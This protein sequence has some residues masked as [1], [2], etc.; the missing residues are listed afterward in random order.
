MKSNYRTVRRGG[1]I[2]VATLSAVALAACSAGQITQTSNQV[3]AVD[4]ARGGDES[5][6]VSVQDVTVI[7]DE[8]TGDAA[9]KF[10][11]QNQDPSG[12]SY[13]L[14]SVSVDGQ[15][16]EFEDEP[17]ALEQNCSFVADFEDH[18]VHFEEY[19]AGCIQ[20]S[21]ST[22]ENEDYAFG[23]NLPVVFTF[24]GLEPIEV[25]ATVAAPTPVPGDEDRDYTS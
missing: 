13:T 20:Y 1:A 23:G 19:E 21:A 2:A 9:L 3:P 5:L 18:F 14:E 12:E 25:T 8:T 15:E 16:V 22:L 24:S 6:G 17:D 7:L 10:T 11:A 4:G